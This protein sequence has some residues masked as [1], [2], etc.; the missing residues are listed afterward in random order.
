LFNDARS[1]QPGGV[2][3]DMCDGGVRLIKNSVNLSDFKAIASSKGG[4]VVSS[5]AN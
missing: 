5:D 4:E 3:V 1:K 2:N